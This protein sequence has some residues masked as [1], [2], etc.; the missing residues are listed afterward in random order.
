MAKQLTGPGQRISE[1]DN[2]IRSGQAVATP[3]RLVN[4]GGKLHAAGVGRT[5]VLGPPSGGGAV[6]DFIDASQVVSGVL[7]LA[8]GGTH[9]DASVTGGSHQA[10]WQESA[11]ADF[12]IRAIGSGDLPAATTSLQGAVVL[13]ANSSDTSGSHVVTADDTRLS[14]ART[15]SGSAGGD[16]SGTYPN[17]TLGT[18]GVTASTYGDST[19]V[20]QF[21]VDAKGRITAASNVGVVGGGGVGASSP[22]FNW[23]NFT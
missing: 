8:R 18:S 3:S 4:V 19:H 22:V 17:P 20:A 15:P 16:L 13:E 5:V 9:L 21:T 7:D 23:S 1:Q 14:D 10:V 11:G 2:L 12:T 6:D